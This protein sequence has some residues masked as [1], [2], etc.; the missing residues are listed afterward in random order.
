MVGPAYDSYH[1]EDYFCDKYVNKFGRHRPYTSLTNEQSW[2]L[3]KEIT[4]EQRDAGFAKIA[5]Y[6]RWVN[7]IILSGNR[8]NVSSVPPG[9]HVA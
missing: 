3:A 8:S 1:S 4:K 2:D 5:I 6:T 9:E 7:E